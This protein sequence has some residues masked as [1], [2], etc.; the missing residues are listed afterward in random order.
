MATPGAAAEA[1][2]EGAS[3]VVLAEGF[4]VPAG[5]AGSVSRLTSLLVGPFPSIRFATLAA[6]FDAVAADFEANAA[7]LEA[8]AA[9]FD[10]AAAFSEAARACTAVLL[11]ARPFGSVAAGLEI[12]TGAAVGAGLAISVGAGEALLNRLA[13]FGMPEVPPAHPAKKIRHSH[14][15][16]ICQ[17]PG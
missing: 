13:K 10:A 3:S 1:A 14:D 4:G 15:R 12:A 17:I 9:S 8:S 2:D 16:E 5:D 7:A 6:C 11:P